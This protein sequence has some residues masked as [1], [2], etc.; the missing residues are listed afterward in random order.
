MPDNH[1]ELQLVRFI[2]VY[3]CLAYENKDFLSSIPLVRVCD[4]FFFSFS[5]KA[6]FTLQCICGL[7]NALRVCSILCYILMQRI[8][9]FY[10]VSD[11]FHEYS[12]HYFLPL[13]CGFVHKQVQTAS[14]T[15]CSAVLMRFNSMFSAKP[16]ISMV[17]AFL[18]CLKISKTKNAAYIIAVNAVQ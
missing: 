11:T 3:D 10:C 6:P 18:L 16:F 8:L 14:I 13:F 2:Q 7:E 12:S 5:S 4:Y 17:P 1:T 15:Q 9:L